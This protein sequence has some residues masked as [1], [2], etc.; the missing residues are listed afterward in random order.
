[1]AVDVAVPVAAAPAVRWRRGV[2]MLGPAFVA[3]VAYVDPGNFATNFAGGAGYGYTL[4]WVVVAANLMAILIQSLSAK[5]GLATGRSLP[6]LCRDSFPTAVRIPLWLQ[7]EAVAIATDLAEVLGGAI[8]LSLLFGVPLPVGG[9]ITGVV[10]LAL[11]AVQTRRARRFEAVIGGL[12]AVVLL[13]FLYDLWFTPTDPVALAGGLVP[14]FAGTESV[15]LAAGIL[16]ATV[17]PHAIYAHSGLTRGARY[18]VDADA[19]GGPVLRW[20]RTDIVLAMGLA[21]F[22]NL[23]MLVVAA[24]LFAG[25][26]AESI[27]LESV[28]QGFGVTVGQGAALAFGLALLASGFASSGVGTYAGQIIMEGFLR[29]RIPLLLRRLV[30]LVP[31]LVVLLLGIDPTRAL[32]VSQVVLSFG[33]PFALIPLIRFTASRRLMGSLVNRPLTTVA[34]VAAAVLIIG[35]NGFLLWALVS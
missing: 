19:S 9:V 16:G 31:A 20:Q 3:A 24:G 2:T 1:M 10:A 17:M 27:T 6:E 35:L 32:V 11:T 25:R 23:T 26:G 8:A 7:A 21:G 4:V 28:Y 30:T 29:R 12:L 15:M 18:G 33:I 5:V 14:T 13:G 22:I 34:A